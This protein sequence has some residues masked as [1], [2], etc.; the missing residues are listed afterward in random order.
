MSRISAYGS[1]GCACAMSSGT[2]REASPM[3][4]RFMQTASTAIRSAQNAASS[5]PAAACAMRAAASRMSSIRWR[6]R[7]R[8]T[9]RLPQHPLAHARLESV[10]RDQVDLA[11]KELFEEEADPGDL[12]QANGPG[13]LDN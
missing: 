1:A 12:E 3:T 9:H 6:Q 5:R 8:G 7:L 10:A 4:M 11:T 13:E 2:W